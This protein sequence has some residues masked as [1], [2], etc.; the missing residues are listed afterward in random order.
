MFGR[1]DEK[2]LTTN[3]TNG[4]R[5]TRVKRVKRLGRR[6]FESSFET[7]RN[8]ANSEHFYPFGVL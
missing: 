2:Y 6:A 1:F 3:E 4:T 8:F 5:V 7:Q